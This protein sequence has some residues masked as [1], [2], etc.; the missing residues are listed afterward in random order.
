MILLHD[1]VIPLYCNCQIILIITW[2]D[3]V[4]LEL[5]LVDYNLRLFSALIIVSESWSTCVWRI[6]YRSYL[7][8]TNLFDSCNRY[9]H[10]LLVHHNCILLLNW[11]CS[12]LSWSTFTPFESDCYNRLTRLY[13][14]FIFDKMKI[15]SYSLRMRERCYIFNSRK[16]QTF[17][18]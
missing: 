5:L 16:A 13:L 17:I 11:S 14:Q 1:F 18:R 6:C 9:W 15:F 4:W 2:S 10:V 12:Q 7:T 8:V 3:L